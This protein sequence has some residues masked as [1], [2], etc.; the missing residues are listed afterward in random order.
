MEDLGLKKINSFNKLPVVHD[1]N[2]NLKRVLELQEN[3]AE[4]NVVCLSSMTFDSVLTE[5]IVGLKT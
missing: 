5:A 4:V 2:T 3:G 1:N